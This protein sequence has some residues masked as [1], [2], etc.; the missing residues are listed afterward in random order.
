MNTNLHNIIFSKFSQNF[1]KIFSKF[2][3]HKFVSHNCSK[4]FHSYPTHRIVLKHFWFELKARDILAQNFSQ[5]F[6]ITIY[7]AQLRQTDAEM[8]SVI[9]P[10][11]RDIQV[12]SQKKKNFFFFF[13][14]WGNHGNEQP[15]S[16]QRKKIFEI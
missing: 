1:L 5:N 6:P 11:A 14:S 10:I 15:R 2:S 16:K 7:I 8:I 9:A 13:R 3:N 4:D 12:H